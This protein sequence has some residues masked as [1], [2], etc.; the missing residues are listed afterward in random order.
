[1]PTTITVTDAASL[2]AAIATADNAAAGAGEFDI[3]F[4]GNIT[5]SAATEL[6]AFNLKGGNTVQVQGG[7]FTLSGGGATRGFFDYA[8][9]VGISNLTI[10][11]AVAAGGAGGAGQE[12]AG[13]GGAGLGGGLFVASGG[14]VTLTN[15]SFTSDS[16]QGG[17]GGAASGGVEGGG[18][19]LGGAGGG[20]AVGGGGGVGLGASGGGQVASGSAGIVLG[21]ASGGGGANPNFVGGSNGGGGAGG[22]PGLTGGGGGG[23]GGLA[24]TFGGGGAGGFG[25]GGGAGDGSAGAGGFGGG[26]GGSNEGGAAGGF[27]GGGGGSRLVATAAAGGFGGGFGGAGNS[28]GGLTG[29]AGGG[30]GAGGAV[31]VQAGGSLTFAGAGAE[32]GGAVTAG[33]TGAPASGGA[34]AQAGSAYGAGLFIQGND[35]LTFS[36]APGQTITI[37]DPIADQTGSGGA[38]ANAGAGAVAVNGGGTLTL[39]AANTYTGGTMV[40]GGATLVA[41]HANAN[42]IDAL[43]SG[44]VT[45]DNG[46]LSNGTGN[47]VNNAVIVGAGGATLAGAGFT[48]SGGFSGA[49][50]VTFATSVFLEGA[51]TRTQGATVLAGNVTVDVGRPFELSAQSDF[52]VAAGATLRLT[53]DGQAQTYTVGSLSGAG[54]VSGDSNPVLPSTTTLSLGAPGASTTFSGVLQD[55]GGGR[56]ALTKTGAGV[57]T[58]TG[59]N[60]YTGATT[61]SGGVLRIGNGGTT[62]SITGDVTDNAT[63]QFSRSDATT[64]AGA[65]SGSGAV[66]VD[67]GGTLTLSN[68]NTYTG[69]TTVTGGATSLTAGHTD[70]GTTTRSARARARS[71]L[72]RRH[73]L[74]RHGPTRP[75]LR[76]RAGRSSAAGGDDQRARWAGSA[77]SSAS[78][79]AS[80]A[81]TFTRPQWCRRAR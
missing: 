9:A 58:L 36:P 69:G 6:Y 5:L 16:A 74:G 40:T 73:E 81:L 8:G 22:A 55:S 45:L 24:A 68:T 14:A 61:I 18:G 41:N 79:P 27:G 2:K 20:G 11:N 56:L 4:G 80:G 34:A 13:G 48:F 52:S 63:L 49:G 32:S 46:V 29:G 23:V 42:G 70:A 10:S 37:G 59:A 25:G 54:T 78:V 39:S 21:A 62:G 60:T 76:Q 7:G 12:G 28:N 1:M 77:C 38:G 67:S 57:F 75:G 17:A 19:G 65:I 15:V 47:G 51:D 3:V 72:L 71:G 53:S 31:F 35:T 66:T 50:P 44:A 26:G 30:L 43:G 33:A 64:F